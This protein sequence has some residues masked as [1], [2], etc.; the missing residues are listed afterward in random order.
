MNP[1]YTRY[2]SARVLIPPPNQK[3][4]KKN[5]CL[6]LLV[7][8]ILISIVSFL[9]VAIIYSFAIFLSSEGG[10][11]SRIRELARKRRNCTMDHNDPNDYNDQNDQNDYNDSNYKNV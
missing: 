4:G 7:D 8:M 5:L 9:I 11:T 1:S 2:G 6:Q 3:K 10:C